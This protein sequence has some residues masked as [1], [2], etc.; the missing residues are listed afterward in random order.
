MKYTSRRPHP[1]SEARRRTRRIPRRL[2]QVQLELV[3]PEDNQLQLKPLTQSAEPETPAFG[4]DHSRFAPQV[5]GTN[6]IVNVDG[7]EVDDG[8]TGF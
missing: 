4:P 5:H 3:F 2:N 1:L 7:L 6:S 8:D